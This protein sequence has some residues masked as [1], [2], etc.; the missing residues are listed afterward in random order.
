MYKKFSVIIPT[1][2]EEGNVGILI[3]KILASFKGMEIIVVDDGSSD[4]TKNIVRELARKH[5]RITLIDRS[6]KGKERGLTSSVIEGILHTKR[7]FAIVID[8]DLQ[9]PPRVIG[10]IA[11]RLNDGS[12]LAVAVRESVVG[13][14]L[15]RRLISRSLIR[16]G[17]FALWANGK[18][19]CSDIFSGFFGVERKLFESTLRK[20][21]RRF[22]GNGYKV[23][24]DFLKCTEKRSIKISEIPYKFNPRKR[25]ASKAGFRQ[26]IAL[27]RSFFT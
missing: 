5:G 14:S 12:D 27:I 1:L 19:T 6:M 15:Y 2:N 11:R 18:A 7:R 22:V 20:N 24:F 9:H 10:D 8:A 13:W 23:L 16:F 21:E 17:E 26:G 3:S 25:G 4:R